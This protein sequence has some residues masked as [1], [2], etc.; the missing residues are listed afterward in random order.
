VSTIKPT[1]LGLPE[2]PGRLI[3]EHSSILVVG[4]LSEKDFVKFCNDRGMSVSKERLLRFER[5]GV[6]CPIIRFA[7]DRD[8]NIHLKVPNDNAAHWFDKG[9]IIDCQKIGSE[10]L[11]LIGNSNES[12]AYY[13]VFQLDDLGW[14]LKGLSLNVA[15]ES[16]FEQGSDSVDW[17]SNGQHWLDVGQSIVS[18]HKRSPFRAAIAI[19]C[20]FI[21]NR[22]YPKTQTNQRTI[23]RSTGS[24]FDK[25]MTIENR[26]WDWREYCRL[27]D[28]KEVERIFSLTSDVLKHAYSALSTSA[29]QIDPLE[30]WANL[31]EFVS[32]NKKQKL[33]GDALHAQSLRDA[34][35]MLGMLHKQLYK[36]ELPP[37]YEIHS[38]I[39][40]HMPELDQRADVRQHMEFVVNQYDLNP[41]PKVV[42][43]VEGQSEIILIERI[44]HEIF[45]H[46]PG[47]FGIE[48]NNL[49]GV[50]NAT[51]GKQYDRFNAIFRLIDYLHH[52]QTMTFL[53]LDDEGNAKHLHEAAKTKRSI[54]GQD[55]L[56][57]PPEHIKIWSKDIEFDNFSDAEIANAL[58]NITKKKWL[59]DAEEVQPA[60][61]GKTALKDVFFQ[62]TSYK[63]S[64]TKLAQALAEI[65]C[66]PENQNSA[67]DDRPLVRHIQTIIQ[68]ASRNPF[69]TDREAWQHNQRS[70]L[71]GGNV[72]PKTE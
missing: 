19:L 56:A 71:L 43:F 24:S 45:G 41:Q 31:V 6:F 14:V 67:Y 47:D 40:R 9:Y 15:L 21:S 66:S 55:R 59:F 39:M 50:A 72:R 13:S 42:L 1:I 54:H 48:L 25:W 61:S 3:M 38:M 12:A 35:N 27:F 68:M 57:T 23:S 46:H 70:F 49:G 63:L 64:K 32:V 4:L 29:N 58:T 16:F 69:P 10:Y 8:N 52:H 51:G 53:I 26:N 36:T 62:K 34:A 22:F 60:R 7:D 65:A 18:S 17:I 11:Q 20:Q 2:S 5:L 44:L 28:P 33:K 30:N 37:T